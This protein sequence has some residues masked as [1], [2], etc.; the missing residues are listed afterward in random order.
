[1][2]KK[3]KK[4][5]FLEIIK[6]M[7]TM[8]VIVGLGI[9]FL[10]V[11]LRNNGDN[12]TNEIIKEQSNKNT[13]EQISTNNKKEI[14]SNEQA[15]LIGKEKYKKAEQY[16]SR[17]KELGES[18]QV[19]YKGQNVNASKVLSIKDI[20]DLFTKNKFDKYI[21]KVKDESENYN[22]LLEKG[23]EYY[24]L[25]TDMGG[26]LSYLYTDDLTVK[27]ID[28]NKIVFEAKS[29]YLVNDEPYL[30][31]VNPK[32]YVKTAPK[33]K[34][35]IKTNKFTIVKENGDWKVDYYVLPF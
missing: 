25:D 31:N 35:E 28:E 29:Y 10:V 2:E 34:I 17:L 3:E 5:S 22:S 20:K 33:D 9:A 30:S 7:L 16:Y 23:G 1:M 26:V 4:F 27:S 15:L 19:E 13:I 32:E 24:R 21:R 11:L 8:I 14:I 12:N 6:I 18:I